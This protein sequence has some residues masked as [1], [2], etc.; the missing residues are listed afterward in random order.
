MIKISGKVIRGKGK[1]K[2][3]G[4]PTVNLELKGEIESGVYKGKIEVG[5]EKYDMAIF[6]KDKILEAHILDFSGDLY[7]KEIEVEIGKKIRDVVKFDNDTD[8]IAQIM[9]DISIIHNS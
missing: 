7:G 9:K 3:L 6:I 1:G 2:E 5:S 8:L 4:F